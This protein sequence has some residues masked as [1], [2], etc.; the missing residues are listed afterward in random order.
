MRHAS[1]VSAGA[2]LG[3]GRAVDA[4]TGAGAGGTAKGGERAVARAVAARRAGVH[5]PNAAVL[6][7][8][9]TGPRD[10]GGG[11]GRCR[12]ALGGVH[13]PDFGAALARLHSATLE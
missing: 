11:N 5:A 6:A 10:D 4:G 13:G 2:G 9:R 7:A 8:W 3:P 1:R 12:T